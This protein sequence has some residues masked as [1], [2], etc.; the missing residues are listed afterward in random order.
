MSEAPDRGE[1]AGVAGGGWAPLRFPLFRRLWTAQFA[2]NVG[3]W[4]QT[5]AAQWV[6]TSLT[7]SA[8]L[9]SAIPAAGSIP[10]LLLAVPAGTLGDL[11]DRRRLILGAQALMLLAAVVLAV[12]AAGDWL[13]PWTLL[14]LLAVI[15]VGG[16]AS[17]PTW[18][19]L[20]PELVSDAER[21]QAIA[22]GSVNQNLARAV[23]PAL[24]GIL[25]AAA[26]AAVV[27][28]TNAVSFLAVLGAVAATKLPT[29]R[30]AMPRE[31][32]AAATRAGGRYVAHS[33]VLLALIAR[34]VVF[35][36]FAGS[37]WALLPLVARYRLGLGSAGYG[38]LL[39]CVG[40]GALAAAT[41]GPALKRRLTPRTIYALA[42]LIVAGASALLA[43][44]HSVALVA[45]ALF[46]AG[47][48][49]IM[50]IGLLGAAYQGQLPVWVKARGVSYYLVAFQGANGV[51]ALC[52]GAIAQLT[53]V[54]TAFLAVAAALALATIATWPVALPE[55]VALD[56]QL[57]EPLPLPDV[58]GT[59]EDGPV[60]VTVDYPVAAG[61]VD[62]FLEAATA[63]R[64]VRRRTGATRWH[65]HRDV[66]DPDV[67]IETFLVGS[68]QEHER[69]HGRLERGDRAVLDHIDT[70]LQPGRRRTAHHAIGIRTGRNRHD[71][72]PAP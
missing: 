37:V 71:E 46:A 60:F 25:L 4:M 68:W 22:L 33:P 50:G 55:P 48:S 41:F 1:A 63:L 64:R 31:H 59:V 6:M 34:A 11:V 45:V 28:L 53:T 15:G 8:V 69:Q 51:G 32:A 27:F 36:F 23:G 39:A 70:L 52:L 16:A 10:V 26:S 61:D 44:S 62:A 14:G 57:A 40:V 9:L 30:L 13:T 54:S 67:F 12:L 42:C 17:A 7:G 65:L 2:S 49:W 19:T 35:I 47:A 18:Q 66:E 72:H 20:Q 21:S 24:G 29:R 38:L 58:E 3:S 5:V 43:V 56:H